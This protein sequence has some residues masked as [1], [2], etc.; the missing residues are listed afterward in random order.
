MVSMEQLIEWRHGTKSN[1]LPQWKPSG[2]QI[3]T[4]FIKR[5]RALGEGLSIDINQAEVRRECLSM[6]LDYMVFM[7]A[8]QLNNLDN[9]IP[10][11]RD[12]VDYLVGTLR[13]TIAVPQPARPL[14]A[15]GSQEAPEG[16]DWALDTAMGFEETVDP[17]LPEIIG[18]KGRLQHPQ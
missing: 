14:L 18:H 11:H 16:A 13:S 2:A 8:T 10:G 3:A 9:M 17:K 6:E 4:R 12:R 1:G 5:L 7:Y 15:S